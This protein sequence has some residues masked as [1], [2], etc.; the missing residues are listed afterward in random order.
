MHNYKKNAPKLCD[1]NLSHNKLDSII[2][3][4]RCLK[5]FSQLECLDLSE[6]LIENVNR[7]EI[8]F[9]VLILIQVTLSSTITLFVVFKE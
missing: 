9:P 6:N 7:I 8:V 4:C 2:V 5:R 3:C 1:L